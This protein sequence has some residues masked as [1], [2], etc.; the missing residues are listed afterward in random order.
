MSANVWLYIALV[1]LIQFRLLLMMLFLM[2]TP[3]TVQRLLMYKPGMM[4]SKTTRSHTPKNVI[5]TALLGAV[6]Q[7]VPTTL[8]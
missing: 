5:L 7:S 3:D 6:V 1:Q 4:R 2:F 8:R